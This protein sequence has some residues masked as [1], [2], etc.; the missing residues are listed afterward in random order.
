MSSREEPTDSPRWRR[1]E[2]PAPTPDE[3]GATPEPAGSAAPTRSVTAK[4]TLTVTV[5]VAVSLAIGF[6]AGR[7]SAPAGPATAAN[8]VAVVASSNPP[9]TPADA[10]SAGITAIATPTAGPSA[11][12]TAQVAASAGPAGANPTG[13]GTVNLTDLVPASSTFT[14]PDKSPLLNGKAQLLSISAYVGVN[15]FGSCNQYTGDAA[16]NLG[17]N[18][19]KFT[20]QIGVDDTSA[21]EKLSPV[22]EV[23]GDG[24]K[25]ATYTPTLGHP[26]QVSVNVTDVLRLDIKFTDTG[27]ACSLNYLVVGDGL[28]T[29]VPGYTPPA[30]SPTS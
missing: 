19:T 16:Y 24:L 26:A 29:T 8:P 27:A 2:P 10:V 7:M 15:Y 5:S 17:R 1:A 25:L 22:V 11:S 28:L 30:P 18:Y 14:N 23:D 3:S 4:A 9:S 12:G 6:T 13:I 20:A 21:D